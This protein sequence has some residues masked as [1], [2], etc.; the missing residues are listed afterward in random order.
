M[1]KPSLQKFMPKLKK[2]GLLFVNTSLVKGLE[3]R[4]DVQV[5]E[6][7]INEL[8]LE[9]GNPKVANMIMLGAYLESKINRH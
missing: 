2:N 5:F 3:Y 4:D 1:N 7:P 6:I 9:I 8:A